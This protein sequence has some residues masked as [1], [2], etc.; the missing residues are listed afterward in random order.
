VCN[1]VEGILCNICNVFGTFVFY[2]DVD[3]MLALWFHVCVS[4]GEMGGF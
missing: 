4:F 1:G 3:A 2:G